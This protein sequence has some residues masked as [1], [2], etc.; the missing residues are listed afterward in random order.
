MVTVLLYYDMEQND[1]NNFMS[2][3]KRLTIGRHTRTFVR[4]ERGR[5]RER[6]RKRE[7]KGGRE[8]EREEERER[9][10]KGGREERG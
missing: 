5:E 6:E 8:R 7:R 2:D 1:N 4:L 9:E 3:N 10:R